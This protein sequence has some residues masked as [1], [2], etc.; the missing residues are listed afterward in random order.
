MSKADT[1]KLR[2][3]AG[4]TV[5]VWATFIRNQLGDDSQSVGFKVVHFSLAAVSIVFGVLTWQ[6]ASRSRR[7][8]T[9]QASGPKE[10]TRPGP[11]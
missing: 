9:E 11:A 4:W 1:L 3:A 5:F 2:L 10:S 7:N 6:V 8:P